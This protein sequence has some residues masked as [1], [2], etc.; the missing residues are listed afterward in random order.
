MKVLFQ[1][2][3]NWVVK[4]MVNV[5]NISGFKGRLKTFSGRSFKAIKHSDVIT[6]CSSQ[7]R[8]CKLL[9]VAKVHVKVSFCICLVSWSSP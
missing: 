2:K 3:R 9:R 4:L 7:S 8:K 1:I 6:T 5:K